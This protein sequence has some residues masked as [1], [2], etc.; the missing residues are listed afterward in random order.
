MNET[1]SL[2]AQQYS[3]SSKFS[4]RIYLHATYSTNKYPWPFWVFDQFEKREGISILEL[5]C[6]TGLLWQV[7]TQ[8]IPESWDVVVSDF[9]EGMLNTAMNNIKGCKAKINFK[10]INTENIEFEESRFDIVI[11]NHML[12]HVPNRDKA[13]EE[14]KRVLKKDGILYAST[15]GDDS[16]LE[17][18]QL[19]RDF[20]K[21]DNYS[22][23]LGSI[24]SSFSLNNGKKQ[25][26]KYFNYVDMKKYVNTL[27]ITESEP[28]V[29]YILSCNDLKPN[30]TVLEPDKKGDFKE[31]LDKILLSK[32][33]INVTI[34][35]GMFIAK[36][37]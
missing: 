12:Y 20:N 35:S 30:L 4:A 36:N 3:N 28:V 8:R 37:I 33:K 31:F 26:D 19:V 34:T 24:E 10:I 14:I 25:L 23:A 15:V 32:S 9:S 5:G 1:G 11:A 17:M 6:G 2:K 18:K 22:L 13:F 29:N 27:E 7:N 16:M 21:N